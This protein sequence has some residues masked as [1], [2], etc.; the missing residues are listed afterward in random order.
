MSITLPPPP[1][2]VNAWDTKDG[3][4]A[5]SQWHG[6]VFDATQLRARDIEVAR[7]VLEAAAQVISPTRYANEADRS[8]AWDHYHAIEA[9]EIRHVE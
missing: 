6:P 3:G 9:L 5:Y 7:V 8:I 2:P 1:V 4:K